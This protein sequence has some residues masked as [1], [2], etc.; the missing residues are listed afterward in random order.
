MQ[1]YIIYRIFRVYE[2]LTGIVVILTLLAFVDDTELF[3]TAQMNETPEQLM[4]RAEVA[5]NLWRECLYVTGGIMRSSKCAW[6]LLDYE[7]TLQNSIM[8][9]QRSNPGSIKMPEENGTIRIVPRYDKDDPREYLGVVQTTNG[10]E[11]EQ[12]KN[13]TQKI[14][15]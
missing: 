6:T 7:G 14:L 4:V 3:L 2:A 10:E 8:L 1:Y 5:I 9:P 13:I 12:V 11:I 15:D